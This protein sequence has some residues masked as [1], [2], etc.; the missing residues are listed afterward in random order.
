MSATLFLEVSPGLQLAVDE[1]GDPQ[2][3]PVFFFHGWP[4]SR[5]QGSGFS[6]EARE[7]GVRIISPD[8]PGIGLSAQQ[9]GRRLLDWPPLVRHMARMLGIERFRVLA[10]SGG[11]PY[12]LATAYA[13]PEHV[14]AVAVVSG[15][16]PLG[17]DVDQR[18]LLPIYRWLLAA[19]RRRP[20]MVRWLF[21]A[22]RPVATVRPPIWAWPC[23][24]LFVP[25]ADRSALRDPEV[26]ERSFGCYRE[27]WR[28][29]GALGV[30]SDAEVYAQDWGFSP[31]EVQVPV[32]LWHGKADR[33]FSW[34]L[35]EALAVRLPDCETRFIEGEGHYSLPIRHR[36]AILQ[37]LLA[38]PV[39]P[40]SLT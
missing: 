39:L 27:A 5:L 35:A 6:V 28:G 22:V 34:R 31:E 40:Q 26:F 9:P 8:R 2:G 36:A 1:C 16:P 14:E 18:A 37:D 11:G 15:A 30:I 32:R 21:H 4:A 13:L 3:A 24:L 38:C 33:S 17:P 25:A 29:A 10:V 7:L 20:G 19:Y 23:L 12:A